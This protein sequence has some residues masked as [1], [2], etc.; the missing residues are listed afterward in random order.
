MKLAWN[1]SFFS[2]S[3]QLKTIKGNTRSRG[4]S[5]RFSL[6]ETSILISLFLCCHWKL[7]VCSEW[8]VQHVQWNRDQTVSQVVAYKRLKRWKTLN[9]PPPPS[10]KRSPSPLLTSGSNYR[11]FTGKSFGVLNWLSLIGAGRLWGVVA[12][13][14]LTSFLFDN[15]P[16][17][18]GR[19]YTSCDLCSCDYPCWPASFSANRVN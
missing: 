5:S 15:R 6:A 18:L 13:G 1:Y 2:W 9:H 17:K 19:L 4:T 11:A 16:T 8:S 12:R 14:G 3:D 7:L 10:H